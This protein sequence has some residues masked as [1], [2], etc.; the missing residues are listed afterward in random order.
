MIDYGYKV[1]EHH[2]TVW[3]EHWAPVKKYPDYFVSDMGQIKNRATGRILKHR[4]KNTGYPVVNLYNRKRSKTCTIHRL[5]ALAFIPNPD[6]LCILVDHIDRDKLNNKASNLRWCTVSTNSRNQD[7]RNKHVGTRGV[8]YKSLNDSW[9]AT[10]YEVG[11]KMQ[12]SV[13]YSVSKYGYTDAKLLAIISRR[14]MEKRHG[15]TI[16]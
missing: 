16:H 14:E 7:V 8:F 10:W 2:F 15:Y 1:G 4:I 3:V 11:N 6:P 12:K 5:V 13:S 9:N